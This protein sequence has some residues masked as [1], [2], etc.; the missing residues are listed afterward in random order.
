MA[1]DS[2]T[3]LRN[4]LAPAPQPPCDLSTADLP[5][6][7]GRR[8]GADEVKQLARQASLSGEPIDHLAALVGSDDARTATNA[9]WVQTHC[10]DKS[11]ARLASQFDSLAE[12]FLSATEEG[13]R[14]LLLHLLTR[15]DAG[16]EATRIQLLDACLATLAD[17]SAAYG[18][19]ALSMQMA[20]R[21]AAPYDALR[22]ELRRLLLALEPAELSPGTRHTRR[23]ILQLL[24]SH[25]SR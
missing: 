16:S 1:T 13:R 11:V 3:S 8:M 17:P 18:L 7:L 21:V 4:P 15:L 5:A 23:H 20:Y 14:R 6:L 2:T 24:D 10:T 22:D 25:S 9:A 12:R 19:R